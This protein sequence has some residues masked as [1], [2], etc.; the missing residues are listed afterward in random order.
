M[1]TQDSRLFDTG[2]LQTFEIGTV[3]KTSKKM[4]IF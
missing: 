1:I 2:H 3:L 4:I